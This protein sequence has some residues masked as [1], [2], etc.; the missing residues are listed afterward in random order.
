[1]VFVIIVI[2]TMNFAPKVLGLIDVMLRSDERRR[3]GGA[4]ALA[5]GTLVEALF[6]VLIAPVAA[7][8]QTIF[9]GGLFL[10]RKVTWDAQE[11]DQRSVSI[12]DAFRGL[13]PQTLMGIGFATSLWV[14]APEFLVWG[15]PVT[16]G[17]LLAAP[18]ASITSRP[19]VGRVFAKAGLCSIPEEQEPPLEL[20]WLGYGSE[21]FEPL[22][23]SAVIGK[24]ISP[25]KTG[26]QGE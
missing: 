9:L 4:S 24:T 10:G 20:I 15:A 26:E 16:L 22:P 2:L 13:W 6:S 23:L 19:D 3:Y 14:F 25:I 8:A 11:R 21:L 1:M 7:L 12:G 18:F 5:I 17:L